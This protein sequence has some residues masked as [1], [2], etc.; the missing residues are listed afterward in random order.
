MM[1]MAQL[2][3][4]T[5]P[6][7]VKKVALLFLLTTLAY[8]SL[9]T[10]QEGNKLYKRTTARGPVTFDEVDINRYERLVTG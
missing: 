5:D 6:L 2:L 9:S 4:M 8:D 7:P 1:L 3:F 10:A